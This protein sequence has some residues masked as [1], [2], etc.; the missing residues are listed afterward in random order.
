[1][2]MGGHVDVIWQPWEYV[3]ICGSALGTFVVANPM[4]TIKDSGKGSVR[5]VY[6]RRAQ[7]PALPRCSRRA[8]YADAGAAQ[9]ASQRGRGPSRR[10]RAVAAVPEIPDRGRQHGADD[11]HL[12]LLPPHHHRQCPNARDR[13]ADGRGDPYRQDRQAQVL[14][15]H[16]DHI[17]GVA[18]ARHRRRRAR[19][20]QGHGRPRPGARGAGRPDRR[21]PGRHVCRHLHLLF[22]DLPDRHPR[23]RS[24]ARSRC[25][26]TSSSSRRC[27]A[28]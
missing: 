28:S 26:S 16:G 8:L 18:G 24:C 9:Q 13:G 5:G 27:S 7:E 6:E 25:A 15:L 10:S 14:P 3:I 4:K 23:S 11:V 21:R 2:A 22:G 1:M 17:R 20:D 12:R 19:G